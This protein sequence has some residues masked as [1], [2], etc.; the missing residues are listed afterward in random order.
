M[1]NQTSSTNST[2][3][4]TPSSSDMQSSHQAFASS[5]V[6][7][8]QQQASPMAGSSTSALQSSGMQAPSFSTMPPVTAAPT[9]PSVTPQNPSGQP[10][11][12]FTPGSGFTAATNMNQGTSAMPNQNMP[13]QDMSASGT[14][15]AQ[16][17][18]ETGDTS[19]KGGSGKLV[20]LLVFIL[21]V[22]AA[23]GGYLLFSMYQKSQSQPDVSITP[24]PVEPVA[25]PT[26]TLEEDP[27]VDELESVSPSDEVEALEEDVEASDFSTLDEEVSALEQ[28]L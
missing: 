17:V 1:D 8:S 11:T 25:S 3:P 7:S 26:A 15:P 22:I 9:T 23:I 4:N 14:P 18:P 5:M 13:G 12:P 27:T 19:H 2:L 10:S 6:Q 21:V 20:F 28:E 24:V 16:S